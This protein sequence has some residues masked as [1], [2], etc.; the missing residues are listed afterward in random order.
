MNRELKA[1][2]DI[3]FKNKAP[4]VV[5]EYLDAFNLPK[6]HDKILMMRYG[7]ERLSINEIVEELGSSKGV[8]DRIIHEAFVMINE[9]P[10]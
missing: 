6:K 2:R 4:N 8:I 5:R 3:Y 9:L 1:I 10:K 7:K